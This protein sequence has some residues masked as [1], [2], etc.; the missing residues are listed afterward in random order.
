MVIRTST[1]YAPWHIIPAND[2]RHA[3]IEVMRIAAEAV[4][5]DVK[6]AKKTGGKH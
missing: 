6:A 4:K 2:K 3:R 1:E 5:R